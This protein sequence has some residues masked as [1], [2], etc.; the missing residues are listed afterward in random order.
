MSSTTFMFHFQQK[1]FNISKSR[2][3]LCFLKFKIQIDKKWSHE[4]MNIIALKTQKM[5]EC[6]FRK[7]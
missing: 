6:D 5:I 3:K 1:S 7:N 4:K 2:L